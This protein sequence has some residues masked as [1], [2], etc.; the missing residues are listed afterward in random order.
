M[1]ILWYTLGMSEKDDLQRQLYRLENQVLALSDQVWSIL[2]DG[3]DRMA[4][5]CAQ[6]DAKTPV[7]DQD[8]FFLREMTACILSQ[9]SFREA[10]E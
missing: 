8:L 9:L 6:I 1:I 10:M 4:Q 3:K 7:S 5:I 2:R